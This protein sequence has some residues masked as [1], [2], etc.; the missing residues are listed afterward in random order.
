M[1]IFKKI[2]I[3]IALMGLIIGVRSFDPACINE[4]VEKFVEQTEICAT[5]VS[6][7]ATGF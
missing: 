7:A 1:K 3:G 2:I 5:F 6:V 4:C